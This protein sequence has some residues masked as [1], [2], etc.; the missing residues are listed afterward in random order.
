MVFV[1]VGLVWVLGLA[2]A[3]VLARAAALA[4]RRTPTPT[5]APSRPVPTAAERFGPKAAGPDGPPTVPDVVQAE[6]DLTRQ[7]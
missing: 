5:A 2:A 7:P 3:L 6:V 1:I 4:D